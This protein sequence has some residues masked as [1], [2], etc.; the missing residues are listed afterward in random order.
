MK[1]KVQKDVDALLNSRSIQLVPHDE[2]SVAVAH[3]LIRIAQEMLVGAGFSL[4]GDEY[5][6][7]NSTCKHLEESRR[8]VVGTAQ[9]MQESRERRQREDEMEMIENPMIA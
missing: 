9:K 8:Q 1:G 6:S 5:D 3:G 2:A 4:T 7:I